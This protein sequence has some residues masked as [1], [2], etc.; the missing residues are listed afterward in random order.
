MPKKTEPPMS[1]EE[2]SRRFEEAARVIEVDGGLSPTEAAEAM[3][4]LVQRA[5]KT[6]LAQV[7]SGTRLTGESDLGFPILVVRANLSHAHRNI[8]HSHGL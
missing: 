7:P 8:H 4:S 2:Q 6:S 5:A 3:E 1:Q